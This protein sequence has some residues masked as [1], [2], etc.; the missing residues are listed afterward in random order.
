MEMKIELPGRNRKGHFS[1]FLWNRN[2]Q[3]NNLSMINIFFD[4]LIVRFLKPFAFLIGWA[5]DY[6]TWKLCI[7]KSL[8]L[9]ISLTKEITEYSWSIKDARIASSWKK[10][11]IHTSQITD[12]F[13]STRTWLH[14]DDWV[15]DLCEWHDSA[16]LSEALLTLKIS[17]SKLSIFCCY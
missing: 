3:L 8:K 6:D 13:V 17:G 4:V 2:A 11:W 5:I 1:I 14:Y 15:L 10:F 12:Y 7:L 16:L 9:S